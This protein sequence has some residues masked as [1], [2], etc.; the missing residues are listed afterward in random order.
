MRDGQS[1][2]LLFRFIFFF[3]LFGSVVHHL[4][5]F[6]SHKLQLCLLFL[7]VFWVEGLIIFDG[8]IPKLLLFKVVAFALLILPGV[9]DP[10]VERD[11]KVHLK[12]EGVN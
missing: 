12:Q 4:V 5:H 8:L 1:L 9:I 2:R 11:V 3:S 7:E 10:G 6:D